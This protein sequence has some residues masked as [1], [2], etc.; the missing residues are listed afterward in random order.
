MKG[1]LHAKI[2]S[3]SYGRFD[4][5]LA[6]DE[7][8]DKDVPRKHSAARVKMKPLSPKSPESLED[9][10]LGQSFVKYAVSP[11]IFPSK[12]IEKNRLMYLETIASDI[13]VV[14]FGGGTRCS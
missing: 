14:F 12:V 4:T 3:Y 10:R 8:T 11:S 9:K 1:S 7:R 6:Y 2:S 13:G 5:I